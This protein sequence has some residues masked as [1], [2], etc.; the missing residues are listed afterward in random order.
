M[1]NTIA[2]TY[3]ILYTSVQGQREYWDGKIWSKY[4]DNSKYV[5]EDNL[6]TEILACEA[7]ADGTVEFQVVPYLHGSI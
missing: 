4:G 7:T 2:Y 1:K 3:F 6:L 5:R